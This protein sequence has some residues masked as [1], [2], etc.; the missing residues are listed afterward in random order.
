MLIYNLH[1]IHK[2]FVEI[3]KKT[4]TARISCTSFLAA[5][6]G[7]PRGLIGRPAV[8]RR[9]QTGDGKNRYPTDVYKRQ[10]WRDVFLGQK[11][12][13]READ[14]SILETADQIR[15]QFVLAMTAEVI[16]PGLRVR[17]NE[18][19]RRGQRAFAVV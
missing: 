19:D 2:F 3:V 4:E 17:G 14:V 1:I 9:R 7:H 5:G 10:V 13:L 6:T 16:D 18:I 12:Q 8:R 15:R 11:V